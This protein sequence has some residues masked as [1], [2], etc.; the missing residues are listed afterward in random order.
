MHPEAQV[1]TGLIPRW[2][3]GRGEKKCHFL[4]FRQR[5][6]Q[7]ATARNTFVEVLGR[8]KERMPTGHE[9]QEAGWGQSRRSGEWAPEP[10]CLGK[11]GKWRLMEALW[12][13]AYCREPENEVLPSHGHLYLAER[14]ASCWSL[15]SRPLVSEA[16]NIVSRTPTTQQ[17]GAT[18]EG[19]RAG[20]V[21]GMRKGWKWIQGK[22]W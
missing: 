3:P 21:L 12:Q 5:D 10:E 8:V 18:L 13:H 4:S 22:Q 9:R 14:S 11:H 7:T 6:W 17:L 16:V 15:S 2:L 20:P 1:Q 19:R